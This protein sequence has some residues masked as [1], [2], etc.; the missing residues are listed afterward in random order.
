[1]N[2]EEPVPF[3]EEMLLALYHV[4]IVTL[5]E[6]RPDSNEYYQVAL[7]RVQYDKLTDLLI[8]FSYKTRHGTI[9]TP[10]VPNGPKLILPS[11]IKEFNEDTIT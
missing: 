1:M 6:N 11:D 2:P 3:T 5:I 8:S 10:L 7:T 4:R 9:S